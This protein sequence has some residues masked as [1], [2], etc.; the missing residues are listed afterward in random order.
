[1]RAE[2]GGGNR[3]G[4]WVDTNG[5]AEEHARTTQGPFA[6]RGGALHA[7]MC[8]MREVHACLGVLNAVSDYVTEADKQV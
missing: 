4:P 1:M 3:G 6:T 5:D 7:C 8:R 2:G